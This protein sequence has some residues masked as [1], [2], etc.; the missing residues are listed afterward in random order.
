MIRKQVYLESHQNLLLRR[1]SELSGRSEA[2]LVREAL[3]AHLYR[4]AANGLDLSAWDEEKQFI[5]QLIRQGREAGRKVDEQ[6]AS[7]WKRADFYE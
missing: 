5:E 1:Q 2:E 7:T 6:H 4:G 3:E